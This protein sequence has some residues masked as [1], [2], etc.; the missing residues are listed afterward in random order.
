[1]TIE[2]QADVV[3]IGG[4]VIGL[5]TAYYLR[6]AGR[7]VTVL[8]KE[9]VDT[10]TSCGN[11]G[12]LVPS[13]VVPLAAPG[14][15]AQGL[16]WLFNPESP[17]YIKPRLDRALASWLWRFRGFCTERHTR[18]SMPLLRDLSL[19]S[20]ELFADLAGLDGLDFL[21][22]RRGL[23]ML[24]NSEKGRKANHKY[25]VLAREVGL[26][27]DELDAEELETLEP[28]LKSP[29]TGAVYFRQDAHLDPGCFAGGLS[30][31]LEQHGVTIHT[32]TEVLGFEHQ[33]RR[34]SAVKTTHGNIE[35]EDV[36][37]A[38]GSWSPGLGRSLRL[39]LPVQPAKGYSVTL[40]HTGPRLRIPTIL[41]EAK[42]TITPMG[43]RI[44]FG[45]T[46]E[47]AGFDASIN[48]RRAASILKVIP[49]YI[50]G[51]DPAGIRDADIWSGY[52]PC[53]PDGLPLLGRPAA[54]ENLVVATGHAMIGITLAP[55]T[56]K[57]VAEIVG[58]EAP[59]IDIHALNV[60]RFA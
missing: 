17:F 19:T 48:R 1:M 30:R 20:V 15:V 58:H 25:A 36:V 47:L 3:V 57:L 59:S 28:E 8:E 13:H 50:P 4:G 2:R 60:D 5:C 43:G 29:A 38:A 55:I 23:L 49:A 16:R 35:A 46:L 37:L 10:G 41:S 18:A 6:E 34:L 14:V 12:M 40:P 7:R 9:T 31:Y 22:E 44:R 33:G 27:V 54:W 26:E 21:F 11:A 53:T 51:V 39:R 52:R 45:G 24:H 56:G 32:G 42:V